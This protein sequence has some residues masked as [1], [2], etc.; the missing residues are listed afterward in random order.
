MKSNEHRTRFIRKTALRAL[1]C[2]LV[3]A[4]AAGW[5]RAAAVTELLPENIIRLHVVANSDSQED[6][7]LKLQV[8]DAVLKEA[9]RWC[10]GAGGF[11]Q[12]NALICTHLESILSAAQ[13]RVA[14]EGFSQPV[15]V[16]V[17]E[18]FFPTRD[19]E[20]F[21]LPAGRYR[22]LR[23]TIGQGEGHNWWC[24][25]FPALCLP[26]AGDG[27]D[28]LAALPEEQRELAENPGRYRVELKV[29]EWYEA[30]REWVRGK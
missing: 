22:T 17:T 6:Q 16:G 7:A 8:R 29:V 11:Q 26:A 18:E 12:A 9:G 1:L 2:G 5:F 10:Q 3:L 15:S 21:T 30:L 4:A 19:Y 28:P 14:R 24:V 13:E 27:G 20:G 25:V 23:V